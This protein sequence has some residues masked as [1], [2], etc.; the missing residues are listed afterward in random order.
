M[1]KPVIVAEW[2]HCSSRYRLVDRDPSDPACQLRVEHLEQDAAGGDRWV[3][4]PIHVNYAGQSVERALLA[5]VYELGRRTQAV[6]DT[7][8]YS[9]GQRQG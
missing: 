8:N 6:A 9:K 1:V 4:M 2:S 7:M 3:D 5:G